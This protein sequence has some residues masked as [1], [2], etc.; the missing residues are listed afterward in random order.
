MDSREWVK[1]EQKEGVLIVALDRPKANAFN[2]Q[3]IEAL[4]GA[5]RTASYNITDEL[6]MLS[7]S[8]YSASAE[9]AGLYMISLM[10]TGPTFGL[11]LGKPGV[12]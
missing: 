8:M 4:H 9:P 7:S 10:T 11:A 12:G 6:L 2:F 5:L 3:M 1:L